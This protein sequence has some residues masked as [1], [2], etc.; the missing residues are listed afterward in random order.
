[1]ATVIAAQVRPEI[2]KC[3][4]DWYYKNAGLQT[5]KHEKILKIMP[6]YMQYDPTAVLLGYIEGVCGEFRK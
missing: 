2:A 5:N 1:M 3:I 4:N 6:Q